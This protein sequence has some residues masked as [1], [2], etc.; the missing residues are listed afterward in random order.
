MMVRFRAIEHSDEDGF[1]AL[2]HDAEDRCRNAWPGR[3]EPNRIM[4]LGFSHVPHPA[5]E[6]C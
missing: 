1:F 5:P 6:R 4:L 3:R 2:E